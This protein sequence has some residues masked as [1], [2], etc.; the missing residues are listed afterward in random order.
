MNCTTGS[1]NSVS[2]K[3]R[4]VR[5]LTVM[6]AILAIIA[7]SLAIHSMFV[8]PQEQSVRLAEAIPALLAPQVDPVNVIGG[9]DGS[10][11]LSSMNAMAGLTKITRDPGNLSSVAGTE[12]RWSFSRI[13]G[14]MSQES[15][16]YQ[17]CG[18]P[19]LAIKHYT[20]LFEERG[21]RSSGCRSDSDTDGRQLVFTR[22]GS[23]ANLRLRKS[24]SHENIYMITLTLWQDTQHN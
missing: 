22:K 13:M 10:F 5:I 11:D 21:Y 15:A 3:S 2:N 16:Q 1:S 6:V 17:Y 7:V 19:D 4:A 24:G 8:E 23:W 12:R 20:E 14:K 9:I 18:S